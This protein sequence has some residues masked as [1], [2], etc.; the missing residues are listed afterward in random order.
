MLPIRP[1]ETTTFGSILDPEKTSSSAS[2]VD[3]PSEA[4]SP[5]ITTTLDPACTTETYNNTDGESATTVS[6]TTEAV[7]TATFTTDLDSTETFTTD[8]GSTEPVSVR[9]KQKKR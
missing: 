9:G 6:A 7:A 2:A 1:F 3:I 5:G 8:E 4:T